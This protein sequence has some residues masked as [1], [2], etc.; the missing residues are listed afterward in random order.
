[1]DAPTSSCAFEEAGC[2]LGL[3]D[4]EPER[5]S[6]AIAQ[7]SDRCGGEPAHTGPYEDM[8]RWPTR[9]V[10]H[11][12]RLFEQ[13]R[14]TA[15]NVK[16]HLRIAGPRTVGDDTPAVLL[17]RSR[18]GSYAFLIGGAVALDLGADGA[19]RHRETLGDCGSKKVDGAGAG[20]ARA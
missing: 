10:E 13:D 15:H 14:V 3:D 17:S 16:G 11:I 1:M 18:G 20:H 7:I 19:E 12:G 5:L 4:D 2:T 8:R 6:P 9:G